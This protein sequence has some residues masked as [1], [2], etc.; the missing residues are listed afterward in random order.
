MPEHQCQAFSKTGNRCTRKAAHFH[1][2]PGDAVYL[3]R[4][5]YKMVTHRARLGSDEE[6]VRKW[7]AL[8]PNNAT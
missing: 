4:M 2:T 6:Q 7:R 8:L 5:H 3:C 1:E